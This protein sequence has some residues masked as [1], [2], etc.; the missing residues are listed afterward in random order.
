M[1]RFD[2]VLHEIG[3]HARLWGIDVDHTTGSLQSAVVSSRDAVKQSDKALCGKR[4]HI[5]AERKDIDQ[6][7]QGNVL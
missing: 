3:V 7:C 6:R 1:Q 5:V 2:Q 4:V